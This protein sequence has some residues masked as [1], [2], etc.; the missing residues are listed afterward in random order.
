MAPAKGDSAA[1]REEKFVDPGISGLTR[2]AAARAAGENRRCGRDR[3]PLCFAFH[4]AS[5]S[6]DVPDD[7]EPVL[8]LAPEVDESFL[9]PQFLMGRQNSISSTLPRTTPSPT[10]M[11]PPFAQRASTAATLATATTTTVISRFMSPPCPNVR[12]CRL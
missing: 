11:T 5:L 9:S 12:C 6:P 10:V 2:P 1:D 8:A 3:H 4:V 7:R